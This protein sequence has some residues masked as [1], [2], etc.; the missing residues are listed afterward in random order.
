MS[1]VRDHDCCRCKM[2][3][4][5]N[6]IP[7]G[8]NYVTRLFFFFIASDFAAC[9]LLDTITDT[10]NSTPSLAVTGLTFPMHPFGSR[11]NFCSEA[12]CCL[13]VDLATLR[14]CPDTLPTAAWL[15]RVFSHDLGLSPSPIYLCPQK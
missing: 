4:P 3:V 9:T 1:E 10:H 6:Y 14:S 15:T 2:A 12:A 7:V 8:E 13:D 5:Q 11:S